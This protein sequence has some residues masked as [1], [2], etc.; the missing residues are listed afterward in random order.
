[1]QKRRVYFDHSATTR[2]DNR[3]AEA[4]VSVM[5]NK[6]G[7]PSSVHNF[8]REAHELMENSRQTIADFLHCKSSEIFFTSGGT[9]ADN[10]ALLGTVK[11]GEHLITTQIEHHAVLYTAEYLEKHGRRVT[12]LKPDR[13]GMIHPQN[14]LDAISEE[15]KL[16]S[17]MHVNNEVG[18]I[19]PIAEI[20]EAVKSRG[21]LFHVDAVQSF[22]KL[23][24]DLSKIPVDMLSISSHKIYGP[25]GVGALFVRQG[26]SVEPRAF[27][28][29]HERGVRAGTENLPG[30]VG[31][32][33]S[34]DI[35]RIVMFE[36]TVRIRKMRDDLYLG[37]KAIYPQ[38]VLNGHPEQRLY[39]LN[40]LSFPGIEGETM[41]M[42][43]DLEG[44]AVSTGSACSS[45][46]TSPSH[47]LQAM[48]LSAEEAH[49]SIRFSL[50][51]ENIPEDIRYAVEVVS[52]V[53]ERLR[54][55]SY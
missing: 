52:S 22:G 53:L 49:S 8:G 39:S 27:G 4:M 54:S 30:I 25:K 28:G 41:L 36:E 44:I 48:G 21:V 17:V 40:N 11:P 46:S 55:M 14:V 6:F 33:V 23:D 18:T 43:L 35:C 20:A 42:S 5:V 37:L 15:S 51:R 2:V 12:Y 47:V 34:A 10:L 45:G 50:G 9:E 32:G 29:H 7:N 16:V 24:I 19:N 31:F 3:V 26:T 13:Y 38:L 1:M